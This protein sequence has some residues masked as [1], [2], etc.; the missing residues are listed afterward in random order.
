MQARV[1][2]GVRN[3]ED[4]WKPENVA[5]PN[6][7]T[8]PHCRIGCESYR[9]PGIYMTIFAFECIILYSYYNY[10]NISLYYNSRYNIILS[11]FTVLLHYCIWGNR[12]RLNEQQ[13]QGIAL[14]DNWHK[15]SRDKSWKI[16]YTWTTD[17]RTQSWGTPCHVGKHLPTLYI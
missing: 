8:L 4:D 9:K 5:F 16:M 13:C 7:E 17:Q 2:F 6:T 11:C 10:I 3:N 12:L 1:S 14:I 15:R